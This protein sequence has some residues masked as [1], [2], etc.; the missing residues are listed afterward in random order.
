M[1]RGYGLMGEAGPEAVMPLKRLA[2]GNLGVEATPAGVTVNVYNNAG[3]QVRTETR[4][5]PGGGLSIDVMIDALEQQ[6][7]QRL[8]RPGTPLNGA[9]ARRRQSGAGALMPTWPASL[10]QRRSSKATANSRRT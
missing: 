4:R 5:E 6:L 9:L 3:A 2:S 10:P 1:A 8:V 7:A